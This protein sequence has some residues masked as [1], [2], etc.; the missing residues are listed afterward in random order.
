MRRNL[1]ETAISRFKMKKIRPEFILMDIRMS[2][3]DGLE[4]SRQLRAMPDFA[5]TPIIPLTASTGASAE[6]LHLKAGI[7]EHLA[8]PFRTDQLFGLLQ[9]YLGSGE[10]RF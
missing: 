10:G 4:A 3:M 1:V 7:T 2:V 6:D 9:R 5:D 8:K